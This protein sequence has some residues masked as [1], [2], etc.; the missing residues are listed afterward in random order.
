ME[1]TITTKDGIVTIDIKKLIINKVNFINVDVI[2]KTR[3]T[4][5]MLDAISLLKNIR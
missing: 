2:N 3:I 1:S 5:N 4:K